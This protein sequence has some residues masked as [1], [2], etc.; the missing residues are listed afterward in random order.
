MQL[1]C[2]SGSALTPMPVLGWSARASV[3][4]ILGIPEVPQP[5]CKRLSVFS[6]K[7]EMSG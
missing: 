3:K 4:A 6:E 7:L 1:A 2:A 5:Q